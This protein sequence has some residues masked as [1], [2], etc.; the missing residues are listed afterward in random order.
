VSQ[1]ERTIQGIRDRGY[2]GPILRYAVTEE[3][4]IAA[5]RNTNSIGYFTKQLCKRRRVNE[6]AFE[7]RRKNRRKK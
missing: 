5:G 4:N 3:E 2:R 1:L 7:S 6:V